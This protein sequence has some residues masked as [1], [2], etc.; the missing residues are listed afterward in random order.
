MRASKTKKAVVKT[1]SL[2]SVSKDGHEP[3]TLVVDIGGS[4][5]KAALLNSHG[6]FL[7]KR[8]RI[9]TPKGA[10]PDMVMK[11]LELLSK[12]FGSFDRLAVGFPGVV[13]NG[14]SRV[15]P[16]LAHEWKGY[17]FATA[18]TEKFAKPVRVM[19]DADMQGYGAISGK[20]VE[21]VLTLGT[22]VGTALFVNGTLVPNVEAGSDRLNAK[23]LKKIGKKRWNRRLDKYVRNLEG[24]FNYERLYI[25]GGNSKHVDIQSLPGNVTICSNLKALIGG[26]RLW[27]R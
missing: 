11:E 25:G 18:L 16:N 10:N 7:N 27:Q 23:A 24:L 12:R 6:K 13:R 22:G 26:A 19:N 5:I 21:F 2:P 4:G 15:A 3:I 14:V 20:G 9:P 8:I 1:N 17:D